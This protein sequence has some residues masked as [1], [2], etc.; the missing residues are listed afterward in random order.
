MVQKIEFDRD[1]LIEIL[2]CLNQVENTCVS[3]K[4]FKDTY[5][6]CEEIGKHLKTK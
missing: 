4:F 3:S 1:L 2:H 5:E 6:I